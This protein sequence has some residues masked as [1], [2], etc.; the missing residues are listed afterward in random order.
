MELYTIHRA[1]SITCFKIE[2]SQTEA[3]LALFKMHSR[4]LAKI[5]VTGNR[6]FGKYILTNAD[7]AEHVSFAA[8]KPTVL[9][10]SDQTLHFVDPDFS[11]SL[12]FCMFLKNRQHLTEQLAFL[13]DL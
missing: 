10:N 13:V 3:C 11:S 8:I 1:I 4:A 12:Y 7:S 2:I 6:N 9:N 5:C